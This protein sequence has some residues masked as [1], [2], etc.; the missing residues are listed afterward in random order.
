MS[1]HIFLDCCYC[2]GRMAYESMRVVASKFYVMA[3]MRWKLHRR[4]N[5]SGFL[6]MFDK[7]YVLR[8]KDAETMMTS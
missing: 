3:V 6:Y 7:I 1:Y 2:I 8:R 4:R 5:E